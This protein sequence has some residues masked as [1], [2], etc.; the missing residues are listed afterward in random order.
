[1]NSAPSVFDRPIVVVVEDDDEM[2]FVLWRR[3]TEVGYRVRQARDGS[4]ALERIRVGNRIGPGSAPA[5]VVSDLR[6]AG[7][8]GLELLQRLRKLDPELP[9]ILI[10]AF[11][12]PEIHAAAKRLGAAASLDKPLVIAQ[13]LE[14]LGRIAPVVAPARN[15][16]P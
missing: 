3:L 14:T 10:T 11:G 7:M 13:L 2:R 1:M 9:V 12:D 5:A 8:G 4:D 6:M 16:S 15:G